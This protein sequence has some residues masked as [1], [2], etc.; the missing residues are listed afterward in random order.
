MMI[1][2][3]SGMS[4]QEMGAGFQSEVLRYFDRVDGR[5]WICT[6]KLRSLDAYLDL[7]R[8]AHRSLGFDLV[9]VDH[10]HEFCSS[11][12]NSVQEQSNTI[13]RLRDLVRKLD[14]R[15]LLVVQPRKE[16]KSIGG[17]GWICRSADILGS[18]QIKACSHHMITLS[19]KPM[20]I[21]GGDDAGQELYERETLV[22]LEFSR[23]C[24]TGRVSLDFDGPSKTFREQQKL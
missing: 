10:F 14:I 9:M 15:M 21:E 12:T 20:R 4:A 18:G 17:E 11:M 13:R 8:R 16:S 23:S 5:W 1:E 2:Q 3:E 24:R 6:S 22:L 19:R 7:V